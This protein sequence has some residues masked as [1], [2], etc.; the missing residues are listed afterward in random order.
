MCLQT[1]ANLMRYTSEYDSRKL[2]TFAG[3]IYVIHPLHSWKIAAHTKN[4][5][6]CLTIW[7]VTFRNVT[8][9]HEWSNMMWDLKNGAAVIHL[10]LKLNIFQN[11]HTHK[12]THSLCLL[13]ITYRCVYIPWHDCDWSHRTAHITSWQTCSCYKTPPQKRKKIM[14]W[15]THDVTVAKREWRRSEQAWWKSGLI[16]HRDFYTEKRCRDRLGHES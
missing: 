13:Y 2:L 5:Q 3:N 16:V 4:W 15:F 10:L 9:Q 1:Y 14:P 12:H 7:T 8:G 11:T 6:K